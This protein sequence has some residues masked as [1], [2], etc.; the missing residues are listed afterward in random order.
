VIWVGGEMKENDTI[1]RDAI[2]GVILL[3]ATAPAIKFVSTKA[4]DFSLRVKRF[5]KKARREKK[6]KQTTQ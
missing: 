1:T 4:K 6:K 3:A 5:G 2:D